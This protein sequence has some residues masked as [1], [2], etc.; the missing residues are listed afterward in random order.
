[1]EAIYLPALKVAV[2]NYNMMRFNRLW[3]TQIYFCQF[4]IP[5][6]IQLANDIEVNPGPEISTDS[7]NLENG[8]EKNYFFIEPWHAE[9]QA[10]WCSALDLPLIVKHKNCSEVVKPLEKPS[11]LYRIVGDGNCLFRALSYAITGRQNYHSLLREKIVQHMRHNEHALLAHMN[12]SVNEYLARTGMRNQHVW[13]TDVEIIAASS[14]LETD[15]YVYTKV[16]FLYKWQRFSS[17]ILSGYP[18]KNVGGLYLQNTS[19]VHYDIVLDVASSLTPHSNHG[20]KRKWNNEQSHH[21]KTKSVSISQPP[22]LAKANHEADIS[23]QGSFTLSNREDLAHISS[24]SDSEL[25]SKTSKNTMS[26]QNTDSDNEI[27]TCQKHKSTQKPFVFACFHTEHQAFWCSALDLPLIVKHKNCSEMVKSLEKPSKLYR[28]VGDGN[29]LFR[30]LSYAITGRQN[31]H[32]LLREKIVQHMRH[33][34]QALLPHINGSVN[35]YLARTGMRNQQVWGT[36]IE[37]IAAS[38]L[39]ETDI[40]EKTKVGF[41]YK[42]QRFSSSILSGYPAK[43]VGGLYLQNTSGVHYDIVLDVASS[44]TAHAN[45]GCKRRR[46]NE[47]SHRRKAKSLSISQPP[48]LAKANHEADISKHGYF[49]LSNREDLAHSSS[50]SDSELTSKN[51]VSSQNTDSDEIVSCQKHKKEGT[52]HFRYDKFWQ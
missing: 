16:G 36:D 5:E 43:N 7:V 21:H 9:C 34:E 52:T 28:I 26:S 2:Q 40:Y 30:A 48:K 11:K 37:I 49:T 24:D 3:L 6:L 50:D 32:S 51:T 31:F 44:P 4:H 45:H 18:A 33:N 23:K 25:T 15:I 41:L 38:S 39:L 1:M 20:R 8:N 19:G 35:E 10:F 17:S 14:L 22:K 29:C 46:N 27:D 42:W 12:G 13:G 47:Q